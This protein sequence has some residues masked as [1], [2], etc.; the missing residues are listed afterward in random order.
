MTL[1][2]AVPA[3]APMMSPERA[4]TAREALEQLGHDLDPDAVPQRRH[5]RRR[6]VAAAL[7]WLAA[8]PGADWQQRWV[9]TG[10][11]GAVAGWVPAGLAARHRDELIFGVVTLVCLD[12]VRPSYGWV[13]RQR[14][15]RKA[16]ALLQRRAEA[17]FAGLRVHVDRLGMPA[18]TR[19]MVMTLLTRLLAVTGRGP[20]AL[21][22]DDFA[23]YA[24][25][26]PP[27]PNGTGQPLEPAWTLVQA[28][29]GLAGAPATLTQYRRAGPL[30]VA[31]LV[32]RY[33]IACRPVRDLLVRYLTERGPAMDYT[34]LVNLTGKLVGLFWYDL[35]RH[36]PGISSLRLDPAVATAWKT[37]AARRPDG[38]PRI[39]YPNLLLAVRAFYLDLVQWAATDPAAWAVWAAPCPV[40]EA[41]LSAVTKA[42]RRRTAHYQQRTRTLAPVLPAWTAAATR[43]LVNAEALLAAATGVPIG[44]TF[45]AGGKQF[46]RAGG[47][48]SSILLV[49]DDD[50]RRLRPAQAEDEAFWTWAMIETWRQTGLRI[51]EVLEV[52]HL[53]LRR[54][55]QPTGDVVPLLQVSPSKT[56]CERVLP[57]AP[58]LAA[59]LARVVRRVK[60]GAATVPLLS[61]FDPYER[62]FGPPLPHLFQR[63]IGVRRAVISP[64]N[65][66]WQLHRLASYA[67]LRDV[68]GTLLTFTPH[69]FRRVF[70][71]ETVN[72]GLPIH[73]AAKL[74][75]HLD[76]GTTQGYVAV[77]PD[78]VI[79]HYRD[80]IA[81]RRQ[82]RPDEEYREPTPAE[83]ADFENHF[84][85][86][87]L[88]LGTCSR[89]YGTGCAHEHACLRCSLQRVDPTQLPRLEEL[90]DNANHRLD[91]AHR[92]GWLGEV[93]ALEESLRHIADKK[94]QAARLLSEPALIGVEVL[95]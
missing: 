19:I 88:A 32:D 26:L 6:A 11:D 13:S 5:A 9:A 84:A 23:G 38:T 53:S 58:E 2:V 71:T 29:G 48:N 22:A 44:T 61:R 15:R 34:S 92:M 25:A 10:S 64:S 8:Q 93:T 51:E 46:T 20:L 47:P 77:Y 70:A 12:A 69:D 80:F 14:L 33:P 16:C 54:Y 78:T 31:Q 68:D 57:V 79:R 30:S 63:R 74:L 91:E 40:R 17:D 56:D 1:T 28:A 52:T 90:Q 94:A 62:A 18:S 49:V 89:P 37:R 72:A 43:R 83:W 27:R 42:K 76:V 66:R 65:V 45:R 24:Q 59:V 41:D 36:H 81:G 67:A 50:G 39:D 85:L 87:K 4:A 86:R 60:A 82:S 73:I 3:R 75:G 35:E 55:T 7:D 95:T 21:T